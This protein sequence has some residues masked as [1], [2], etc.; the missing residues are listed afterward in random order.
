MTQMPEPTRFSEP[1]WLEPYPDLLLEG[2][3]DEAPGPEARYE[4][5]EAIALAFI[6]G[7]QHLPPLPLRG[8]PIAVSFRSSD[9][10]GCCASPVFRKMGR[11]KAGDAHAQFA[12]TRQLGPGVVGRCRAPA[13]GVFTRR[14]GYSGTP[15]RRVG[16]A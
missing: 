7:L 11:A 15:A 8:S 14:L 10:R 12:L 16:R 6:V 4:T 13:H 9:C 3:P 1:V 2:I 5:K